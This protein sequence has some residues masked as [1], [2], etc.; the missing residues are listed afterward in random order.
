MSVRVLSLDAGELKALRKDPAYDGGPVILDGLGGSG[1]P[2]TPSLTNSVEVR[3]GVPGSPL[4]VADVASVLAEVERLGAPVLFVA[5]GWLGAA[6]LALTC[7]CVATYVGPEAEIGPIDPADAL[8]L[9]LAGRLTDRVGPAA[10]ARLLLD[11]RPTSQP[12]VL[13][14]R[15]GDQGQRVAVALGLVRVA[16]DPLAEARD[17]AER[18]DDPAGRLLVRSLAFAARSTAA[19]SAAYDAELLPLLDQRDDPQTDR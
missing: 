10:A 1:D 11:P 14:S 3:S 6:G 5:P 13:G 12:V 4:P 15:Q 16:D 8:A 18:L 17:L 7:A 9:G 2:G 19:Q